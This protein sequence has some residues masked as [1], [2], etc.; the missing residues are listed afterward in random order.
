MSIAEV[1]PHFEKSLLR[2]LKTHYLKN[3]QNL[4]M[5]WNSKD[6]RYFARGIIELNEA[7]TSQR[8]GRYRDYFADPVLRSGYLAYF[9]T[10]NAAKVCGILNRYDVP[11]SSLANLHSESAQK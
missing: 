11:P 2:Y 1:S 4:D 8:S 5:R 7:F 10:V 3:S 6:T 9:L